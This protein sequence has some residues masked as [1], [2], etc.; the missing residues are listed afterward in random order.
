MTNN[1][2]NGT[3]DKVKKL[4]RSREDKMLAGVC[5]GAAKMLGVDAALLRIGLVAATILGFGTGAVLYVACWILM[6]EEET[7][8]PDLYQPRDTTPTF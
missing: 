7:G 5:G 6:P 3:T 1:V 2:L 8:T 4:R